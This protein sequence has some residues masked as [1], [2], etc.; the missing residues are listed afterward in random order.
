MPTVKRITNENGPV[1]NPRTELSPVYTPKG[2]TTPIPTVKTACTI[3]IAA[4]YEPN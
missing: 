1:R 4:I 2:K 3:D